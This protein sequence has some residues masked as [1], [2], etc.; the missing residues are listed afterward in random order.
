MD[1]FIIFDFLPP[2]SLF[3]HFLLILSL[4]HLLEQ[5]ILIGLLVLLTSIELVLCDVLKH[6]TWLH[7]L[8]FLL[9]GRV[10]G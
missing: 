7:V 5:L 4:L 10:C 3:L 9:F 1:L 6:V 8:Y 2:H